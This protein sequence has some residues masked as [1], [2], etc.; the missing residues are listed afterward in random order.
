M[1]KKLLIYLSDG[2]GCRNFLYSNFLTL[3]ASNGFEVVILKNVP[4]DFETRGC[5]VI[6]YPKLPVPAYV[7]LLKGIKSNAEQNLYARK[8]NNDIYKRYSFDRPPSNFKDFVKKT[9]K[10]FELVRA[11]TE[12]GI[13]KIEE[14]M[15]SAARK[16][17]IF[18]SFCAILDE[19]KPDAVLFAN[20][21][22]VTNIAIVLAAEQLGI[23]SITNIFSW[24]N[25]P[26]GIKIH[27]SDYY[28]VW[29]QYMYDEM[30]KYYPRTN[31]DTIRITG[32]PQFS[33]YNNRDELTPRADFFKRY[34][35][36]PDQRYI[37]FS[38]D[39]FTSSP[40]D[41]VY[42]QDLC[43]EVRMYNEKND[44]NFK[45]LF[46]RCPVDHSKRY[47]SVLEQNKDIVTR[48]DPL[49]GTAGDGGWQSSYPTIEDNL[50]LKD[51]LFHSELVVNLGSTVAIDA[52][53][54]GTPAT[55]VN[56]QP[57]ENTNWDIKYNYKKI[58]FESYEGL[59][60]VFWINKVPDYQQVLHKV[61]VGDCATV[62][63]QAHLW[64]E[65]I[66]LHPIENVHQRMWKEIVAVTAK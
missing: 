3:A 49:W 21:R 35:L 64:A 31:P 54:L 39:D 63:D 32:T 48:I 5:R 66:I 30:L 13:L 19:E 45:V 27:K 57:V 46:R 61:D 11:T 7:D 43:N 17:A 44:S 18:Q 50:L 38:G 28:F 58:H 55:Y 47:D 37:C 6:S 41:E 33:S 60:P 36:S 14:R 9:F 8:F 34:S 40:H 24:D 16:S 22:A 53:F 2:V 26:K 42:L 56:Y 23:P 4:F 65:R 52:S 20:Q 51:I 29:S 12:D 62:L 25:L 1:K 10:K 15:Y 59:T